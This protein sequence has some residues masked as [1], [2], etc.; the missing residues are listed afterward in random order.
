M[1]VIE[2]EITSFTTDPTARRHVMGAMTS[3]QRAL[4]HELAEAYGLATSSTG[5]V[6]YSGTVCAAQKRYMC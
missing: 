5:C 6:R 3:S 4:V 2:R 1:G